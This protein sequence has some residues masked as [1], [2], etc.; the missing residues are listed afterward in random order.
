MFSVQSLYLSNFRG[1][2]FF[3]TCLLNHLT[4]N[5][6]FEC[7]AN[8]VFCLHITGN[9]TNNQFLVL[10]VICLKVMSLRNRNNI[11]HKTWKTLDWKSVVKNFFFR[12]SSITTEAIRR[13]AQQWWCTHKPIKH[14]RGSVMVLGLHFSQK[15]GF[16]KTDGIV[17]AEKYHQT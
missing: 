12:W 15:W 11:Q 3:G 10:C 16:I 17:K 5:K 9:L 4:L 6:L 2:I 1:R 13:E 14:C 8:L 7:A